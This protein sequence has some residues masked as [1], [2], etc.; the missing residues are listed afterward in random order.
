ML[1]SC[2]KTVTVNQPFVPMNSF[3]GFLIS[4]VKAWTKPLSSVYMW[5]ISWIC[6]AQYYLFDFVLSFMLEFAA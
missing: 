2:G 5:F 1:I 4:H 6:S 3:I